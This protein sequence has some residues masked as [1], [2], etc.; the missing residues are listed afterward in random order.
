MLA[1]DFAER[2]AQRAQEIGVG[3]VDRAVHVELD[4]GLRFPDRV[5]V[6]G[7][8]GAIQF[9]VGDIGCNLH[10]LER[11]FP[12]IEDWIVAGQDPDFPCRPCRCACT[13]PPDTHR[14]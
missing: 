5:D 12:F 8:I 14:D 11:L 1:R 2:I 3:G 10:H 7:E 9:L 4:N 13:P 6:G